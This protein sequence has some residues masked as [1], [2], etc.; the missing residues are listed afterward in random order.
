MRYRL[1]G[2]SGLRVSEVFLGAMTFA[3]GFAPRAGVDEARR[4]V[5]FYADAGGN[6]V[7]TA[8]NYREG[9]SEEIVGAVLTGRRDRF[10]LATKYDVSRGGDDPNAAGNHR[11]NLRLSLERSLRQLR[12]DYID[13]RYVHIWDHLTPVEETIRTLDDAVRAGKVLHV[14]L[15]DTPAWVA[16][17]ADTVAQWR[18]W[19]PVVALQARY[20]LSRDAERDLLPAA[21]ALG[22]SVAVWSPLGG[23]VLS[24]KFTRPGGT[25]DL[26]RLQADSISERDHSVAQVVQDVADE[27]AAT[28]SQVALA[29]T[30]SRSR[31]VHPI[32]GVRRLDQLLDNLGALDTALPPNSWPG[33]KPPPGSTSGSR[34]TSSATCSRSST[35]RS[36][37]RSMADSRR[38]SSRSGLGSLQQ[39][40]GAWRGITDQ[41]DTPDI[42]ASLPCPHARRSRSCSASPGRR[43]PRAVRTPRRGEAAGRCPANEPHPPVST[44]A[45]LPRKGTGTAPRPGV[46]PTRNPGL[47]AGR[48]A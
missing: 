6:V 22:M 23:G 18:G 34:T 36:V 17:R 26:T 35:A 20:L 38:P 11:K 9:A 1:L 10:V 48:L 46:I 37:P 8:V 42:L 30:M 29:W 2:G 13:L 3:E 31:A 19:S 21:E 33:S 41:L 25:A 27:L 40:S 47:P 15:S 44:S 28:P 14:G 12:T 5:D 24:G 45:F 32:V 7:D 39:S 43:G 4:I 16:A